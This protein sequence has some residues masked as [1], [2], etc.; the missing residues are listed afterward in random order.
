MSACFHWTESSCTWIELGSVIITGKV[1]VAKSC[2]FDLMDCSLP[3]SSV[4]GIL[5]A[6]ILEWVAISFSRGFS[7]PKDGACVSCITGKFFTIWATKE[8]KHYCGLNWIFSY[9]LYYFKHILYCILSEKLETKFLT[10][11]PQPCPCGHICSF[12]LLFH[13][14]KKCLYQYDSLCK[15]FEYSHWHLPNTKSLSALFYCHVI[16]VSL[17]TFLRPTINSPPK[18]HSYLF[19]IIAPCLICF[20]GGPCHLD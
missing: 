3:G 6:R 10:S 8:A 7:L 11:L 15:K 2:L 9:L 5:Q 18:R 12:F 4:H 14:N 13:F 20:N 19:K 16:I 1:L 17:F